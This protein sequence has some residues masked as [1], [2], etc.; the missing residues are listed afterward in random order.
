M[1]RG[2]L[3]ISIL[4]LGE[5]EEERVVSMQQEVPFSQVVELDGVKEDHLCN[6]DCKVV[7]YKIEEVE[8]SYGE[9]RRINS[10]VVME[11][12]LESYFER[13]IDII[14]DAYGLNS[15]LGVEKKHAKIST[16]KNEIK[17][18]IVLKNSIYV[19]ENALG[20]VLDILC[21]P[22]LYEIRNSDNGIVLEGVVKTRILYTLQEEEN[23]IR[24]HEFEIPLNSNL[25]IEGVKEGSELEISLLMQH[26]NYSLT[27][28]NEVEIR[29]VVYAEIKFMDNSEFY[30]T[31]SIIESTEQ[32]NASEMPSLLIY[33][34][35]TGDTLWD[36]A[37]RYCTTVAKIKTF[38]N[39]GD[40]EL[41]IPGQQIIIPGKAV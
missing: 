18:E 16:F 28:T 10:E 38:N 2:E 41:V 11:V 32:R 33:F 5:G 23:C 6:V 27:S 29:G 4:Y 8:D 26:C 35:Q 15:V 39:L 1:L 21:K 24:C 17:R 12:F 40:S 22:F 30:L 37:K 7:D 13:E 3:I 34:S 14:K 19:G 20:K 36:I 9:L 25:D 31:D